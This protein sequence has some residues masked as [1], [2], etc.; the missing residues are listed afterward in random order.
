VPSISVQESFL[1]I[2]A[3]TATGGLT[4]TSTDYLYPGALAWVAKDDG[5]LS[6]RVKIIAILSETTLT[7]R[8]IY[9]SSLGNLNADQNSPPQYGFGNM[10][11]FNAVASHICMECQNV[12][13]DPAYRR[14]VSP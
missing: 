5:S 8:Q 9:G 3:A 4:V 14:R 10:S 13:V 2:S 7:V 11:A 6:I 12:P 1:A